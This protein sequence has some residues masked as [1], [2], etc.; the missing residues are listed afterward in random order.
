MAVVWCYCWRYMH[1]E[2]CMEPTAVMHNMMC[3]LCMW[4]ISILHSYPCS[5]RMDHVSLKDCKTKYH[6]VSSTVSSLHHIYSTVIQCHVSE[7]ICHS[8]CMSIY[9]MYNCSF[10][11]SV[12]MKVVCIQLKPMPQELYRAMVIGIQNDTYE[13]EMHGWLQVI[14]LQSHPVI[15]Q[16]TILRLLSAI[17]NLIAKT[18]D[19]TKRTRKK[20]RGKQWIT[21]WV[22]PVIWTVHFDSAS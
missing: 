10:I 9:C 18:L 13:Q 6:A 3:I 17:G 19:L 20:V 5:C 14:L 21:L 15:L 22:K 8:L 12:Q 11:Q 2:R 7:V 1:S 16:L 4:V